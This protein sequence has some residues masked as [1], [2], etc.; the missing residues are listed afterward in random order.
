MEGDSAGGSAKQGR[1]REFQAILP[2]R[3]KILNV[4][5]ARLDKILKNNEIRNLITAFGTNIGEEFDIE[6]AR[7]HKLIIMT[8]ADIDGAHI[9]T[10]LLTFLYRYM[11][12]LIEAGYVYIAQPPLYRVSKGK[13]EFWVYTDAEKDAL[14]KEKGDGWGVQRY[15]GLG[16]MNDHQLWDTTMDPDNWILLLVTIDD[17]MLAD[18]LFTILMGDAVEPRRDFITAHAKD[19]VNLDV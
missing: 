3:G 7:Y 18:E 16:E 11:K 19:V 6:K 15:K 12:P 13:T 10:L 14:V 1:N 9:R 5:K 8:D 2:L 17:A 4:E